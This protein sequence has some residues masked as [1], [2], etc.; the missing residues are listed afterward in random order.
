MWS[1]KKQILCTGCGFLVWGFYD[2]FEGTRTRVIE[3]PP[4]WR[5]RI[6]HEKDLGELEDPHTGERIDLICTRR[7]WLWSP[8]VDTK[9]GHMDVDTLVQ[10]RR[11]GYYVG[12]EPGFG[13]EEHKELK[14]DADTRTAVVR[15]TLIGAGI[16]AA[17]AIVAQVLYAVIAS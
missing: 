6:Q 3:C 12:Y 10:R 5:A 7:Q 11:C 4:Y 2:P 15:A 17:A 8:P 14:R 1:R 13:P 16:G 9:L